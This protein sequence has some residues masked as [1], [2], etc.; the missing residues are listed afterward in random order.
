MK[1]RK[2]SKNEH[3]ECEKPLPPFKYLNGVLW[4]QIHI[5]HSSWQ[6][7]RQPECTAKITEHKL[8]LILNTSHQI[9]SRWLVQCLK[10]FKFDLCP[11]E[12]APHEKLAIAKKCCSFPTQKGPVQLKKLPCSAFLK[13]LHVLHSHLDIKVCSESYENYFLLYLEASDPPV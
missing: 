6:V 1:Q 13:V 10:Y 7:K 4:N 8:L 5:H 12:R 2:K 11:A 9:K 3:V